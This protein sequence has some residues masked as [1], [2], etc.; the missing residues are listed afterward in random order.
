MHLGAL[1]NTALMRITFIIFYT[2][3]AGANLLNKH[4]R[5]Y[6]L[7]LLYSPPSYNSHSNLICIC[8]TSSTSI[9]GVI[10]GLME[11]TNAASSITR[12]H[13]TGLPAT[14]SQERASTLSSIDRPLL[15]SFP[16]P[17]HVT[18]KM[19]FCNYYA[20]CTCVYNFYDKP[21]VNM[22]TS[23]VSVP[24]LPNTTHAW[25][26]DKARCTSCLPNT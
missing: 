3:I 20:L 11:D 16:L 17:C 12:V 18:C 25:S 19:Y 4:K 7:S 24:S 21:L 22:L 14:Y 8:A 26:S 13:T 1:E 15:S 6:F 2:R 10:V 5:D 23:A 9:V